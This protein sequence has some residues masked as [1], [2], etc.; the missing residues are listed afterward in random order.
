[1]ATP[2]KS[3]T[4]CSAPSAT[5]MF[6]AV[7]SP[8]THTGACSH[9]LA[10]A[11]SHTLVAALASMSS[12]VRR[13]SCRVCHWLRDRQRQL[14]GQHRQPAMLLGDLRNAA[15]ARKADGQLVAEPECGVVL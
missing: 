7:R 10:R 6:D 12:A 2:P 1:M 11:V 8:C 4:A 15:G 5:S 3:M 13:I 9:V 14:P